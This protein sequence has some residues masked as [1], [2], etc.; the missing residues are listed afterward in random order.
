VPGFAGLQLQNFQ[1][2]KKAAKKQLLAK[3]TSLLYH[4]ILAW[5]AVVLYKC[6]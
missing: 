5:I 2:K 3:P 6:E 4:H 1:K